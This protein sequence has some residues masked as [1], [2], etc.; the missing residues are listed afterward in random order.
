MFLSVLLEAAHLDAYYHHNSRVHYYEYSQ[1]PFDLA[2]KTKKPVFMLITAVWCYW[3]KYFKEKALETPEVSEYLNNNFINVFVDSDKRLDLTRKYLAFGWPTVVLFD[4]Q[5]NRQISFAGALKKK[6][7]LALLK[8]QRQKLLIAKADVSLGTDTGA[9]TSTGRVP[10]RLAKD[11]FLELRGDL[12]HY[13]EDNFDEGYGG[14]G[15]KK[16]YPMGNLLI[17]LL[18]QSEKTG[19]RSYVKMVKK[20]LSNMLDGLY[21]PIEGGFHRYSATRDWQR[22][23]YEKMTYTNAS[24]IQA[25]LMA[26][27]VTGDSSYRKVAEKTIDYVLKNLYDSK[28]GGFYGSQK[29]DKRYYRLSSQ[30]RERVNAPSIDKNKSAPWN[31]QMILAM[32]YAATITKRGELKTAASKSLGFLRKV[33]LSDQGVYLYLD[34]KRRKPFLKGQLEANA[35]AS[36]AFLQGYEYT[37]DKSFLQAAE[38]ILGYSLEKLFDRRRGVFIAWN[39]P[40]GR[41]YRTDEG[42]S[43]DTPLETN[44]VMALSLLNAYRM[45]KKKEYLQAGRKAIGYFASEV[46]RAFTDEIDLVDITILERTVYFFKAYQH[47]LSAQSDN[48]GQ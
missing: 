2:Q 29:A 27:Q 41:I 38:K 43:K 46:K 18:E 47:L 25:Y 39:N 31:S 11:T 33:L 4:P 23:H 24:L 15:R 1:K 10:L 35:W 32:F 3:C 37:D 36:L 13:L 26:Y 14:F 7:L 30:E 20:S 34:E 48:S 44:G 16:K 45:T 22:P 21:D 17:Y 5:G 40:D 9:D 12:D 28:N 6:T 42:V 19:Q 8:E